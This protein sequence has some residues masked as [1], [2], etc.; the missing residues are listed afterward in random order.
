MQVISRQGDSIDSLCWRHYGRTQGMVEQVLLANQDLSYLE[1]ILPIGTLIELPEAV[2]QPQQ[3][4]IQL[5]D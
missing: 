4:M 5:W 3:Q 2:P 1:P